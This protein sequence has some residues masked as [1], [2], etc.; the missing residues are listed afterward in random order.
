MYHEFCTYNDDYYCS[1]SDA[2]SSIFSALN[3]GVKGININSHILTKHSY[4]CQEG[5]V[6][7]VPVDYPFGIR[8]SKVRQMET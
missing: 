5:L 7:S 1:T 2:L 8:D 6:L 3:C 4:L